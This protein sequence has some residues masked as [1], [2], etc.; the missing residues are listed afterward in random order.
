MTPTESQIEALRE[1]INVGV[2]RGASVLNSMLNSHIHLQV[3]HIRIITPIELGEQKDKLAFDE[4][5]AVVDMK[6][7]GK[8]SGKSQLVFPAETASILVS[9]LIGDETEDLDIDGIRAGTLIEI[10]NVVL[11]NLLGSISNILQLS[12]TYSVPSYCEEKADALF[13]PDAFKQ[14]DVILLAR[15]RFVVEKLNIEGDIIIVLD[16]DAMSELLDSLDKQFME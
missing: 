5:L 8:F 16:V 12:F 15:T 4:N 1:L 7:K 14:I 3:P 10:G 11:N 6:F 13:S 2:G 9:T